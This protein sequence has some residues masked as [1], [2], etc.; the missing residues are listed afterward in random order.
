MER[1]ITTIDSAPSQ[2]ARHTVEWLK[3][4]GQKFILEEDWPANSPGM[5]PL[6]YCVNGILKGIISHR[7]PTT[8]DGMKR[9]IREELARF[10]LGIIRAACQSGKDVWKR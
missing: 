4:H 2:K 1:G 8:E 3:N 7:K 10:N 6:G 5:A 9:V